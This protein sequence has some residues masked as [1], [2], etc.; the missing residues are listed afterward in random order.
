MPSAIK[1]LFP[2]QKETEKM[3]QKK[4]YKI[5]AEHVK[6]IFDSLCSPHVS[7]YERL[8]IHKKCTIKQIANIF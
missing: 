6:M 2:H 1:F 3:K 7:M 8:I 5:P 4:I